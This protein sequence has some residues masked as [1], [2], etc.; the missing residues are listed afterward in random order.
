M[1]HTPHIRKQ[2][3]PKPPRGQGREKKEQPER[4]NPPTKPRN[5]PT[6]EKKTQKKKGPGGRMRLPLL[7]TKK[8]ALRLKRLLRP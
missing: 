2:T 8:I 3:Q 1:R 4:P 7:I 6:K 5:P